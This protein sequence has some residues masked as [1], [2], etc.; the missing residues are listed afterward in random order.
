MGM[1]PAT[2]PH[3]ERKERKF[4]HCQKCDH[5]WPPRPKT[6]IPKICPKCKNPKWHLPKIDG[7]GRPTNEAIALR[8]AAQS[9]KSKK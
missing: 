3:L 9:A 1:I 4:W 6:V 8:E 2:G 5:V 7:V